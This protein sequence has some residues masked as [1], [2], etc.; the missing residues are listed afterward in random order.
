MNSTSLSSMTLPLTS[1]CHWWPSLWCLRCFWASSC[2]LQCWCPSQL[3][4]SWSICSESC[5]CGISASMPS[6]W[7]TLS[8]WVKSVL[9]DCEYTSVDVLWLEPTVMYNI[10]STLFEVLVSLVLIFNNYQQKSAYL[11]LYGQMFNV[12]FTCLFCRV[13]AYQW[14]SAAI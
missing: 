7:S 11:N 5:G 2:G 9:W 10:W 1:V 8:W 6:H 4:W 3:P 12:L 14:S 13:V